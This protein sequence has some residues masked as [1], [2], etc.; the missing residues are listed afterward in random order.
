MVVMLVPGVHCVVS[1]AVR[2]RRVLWPGLAVRPGGAVPLSRT[3][4][5]FVGR[6]VRRLVRLEI[7]PVVRHRLAVHLRP[8]SYTAAMLTL[9]LTRHGLTPRSNPEQHLGQRIDVELSDDGR[10]QARALAARLAGVAFE[11]IISSPLAR[12]RQTAEIVA[13]A[14]GQRAD[15]SV[16][17][18]LAE[19][20]FGEWEGLTY[21]QIYERDG[22]RRR[23]WEK[24]PSG[25]ACPGGES[26][27]DVAARA[28]GFL[29]HL[30]AEHVDRHGGDTTETPPVLAVAHSSLNRVLVCV[31]LDIPVRE[32]R[33]RLQ[34]GQ[35][36]LTA[37][38]FEHGVGPSDARLVLL[39]DL[40][41][42]R[43]ADTTPWE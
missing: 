9:V 32:F 18:R 11:R 34:Q 10:A 21:A 15:L 2:L 36:N 7:V 17:A 22:D 20:D 42:I 43:P 40:A 8:A 14:L 4:R 16:D 19:M 23:A 26:A 37:L 3:G 29:E 6:L 5:R 1:R 38:R 13:A 31:A 30:L 25:I 33:L 28:R 35:V 41:H 27:D 39:N 12:A 24:D